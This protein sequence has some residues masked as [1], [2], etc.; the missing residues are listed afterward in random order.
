MGGM[1]GGSCAAAHAKATARDRLCTPQAC[2]SLPCPPHPP[3]C[4][5][6]DDAAA[7]EGAGKYA[8]AFITRAD[9]GGGGDALKPLLHEGP[10]KAMGVVPRPQVNVVVVTAAAAAHG[11][12]PL[13]G[14]SDAE[15]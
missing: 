6:A 1:G 3:P 11:Y 2:L 10:V 9:G 14:S 5:A 15:E 4:S 7:A 8:S 12:Q 13:K